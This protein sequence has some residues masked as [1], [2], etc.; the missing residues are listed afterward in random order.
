MSSSNSTT[1]EKKIMTRWTALCAA[2][3][4]AF[5]TLHATNGTRMI[6][7]NA[8][9]SG[10]GG[11]A[12]GT[13]DSPSLMMTNPAGIAFI[14][15]R[16]IDLHFAL[17]IPRLEFRNGLNNA[18]GTRHAY[19]VPGIAFV[20][21]ASSGLSW[22]IGAFA[23]GG[24]GAEFALNHDLFR[25]QTGVFVAQDYYSE[26]AVMQGGPSVAYLLTPSLA[27]GAS[28]HLVY[29]QLEFRMPYSL[30]P[31]VMKGVANPLTGMTFGDM[32]A[33]PPSMGGFGYS[34]VTAAAAMNDLTA[35]GF[36]G[37]FGLAWKINDRTS[38][39]LSYTSPTTLSYKNGKARMDM[40]AQLND[41]FGR[42][43]AGVMMQNPG[44]TPEQAQAAVMQMFAGMGIDLAQGA[45]ADYDLE[46]ELGLP[47]SIGFGASFAISSRMRMSMDLE[48][49][50]WQNAFDKMTLSMSAGTNPNINRMM[51][52]DGTFSIEF[53]MNWE[54]AVMVRYGLEFDV[55]DAVTL[56]GGAAFGTNPVPS[57]TVFPV[58]PAI[59]EDHATLGATVRVIPSLAI[60]AAVEHAFNKK[61]AA[62]S[63]SMLAREYDASLSQLRENIFHLSLTWGI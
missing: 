42:A 43:V 53:P 58:F 51:G 63:T 45:V 19:P 25:D 26:L 61:Q 60:H 21:P 49:I 46:A 62:S 38:V 13:F 8:L 2:F 41:A 28:A 44:M 37:K 14:P 18:V 7:F 54:D 40:T 32:F 12:I 39:G 20:E 17:M 23:Q 52:N 36:S 30:S 11:T 57:A 31:S 29:S 15:E 22:G 9:T 1:K 3:L 55:T 6:G 48:W 10:R 24:M 27:I 47:Q 33:A 35:F 50:N 59:V 16:E 56:R 34:E 4:L 5:S